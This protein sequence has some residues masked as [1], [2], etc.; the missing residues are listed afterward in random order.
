MQYGQYDQLL[1]YAI[2]LSPPL[3]GFFIV[4]RAHAC[5]G[6]GVFPFALLHNQHYR[7]TELQPLKIFLSPSTRYIQPQLNVAHYLTPLKSHG[8]RGNLTDLLPNSFTDIS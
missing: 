2:F 8:Q 4:R 7:Y 1:L 6:L 5:Q 3:N